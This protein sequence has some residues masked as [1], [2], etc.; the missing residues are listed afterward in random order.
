VDT[1]TISIVTPSYQQ[2][3]HLEEAMT[4]VLGQGCDRLEYV[5]CDGGS[6][7]GSRTIIERYASRLHWWRSA[8]DDGHYAAINEGFAHTTGEIMGWLNSDDRYIPGALRAVG[9]IFARF[10]TVE[11]ITSS[12]PVSLNV[13]SAAVGSWPMG[14]FSKRSFL[15]GTNLPRQGCYATGFV[16]QEST[17]WRR[18]LWERTGG[19]DTQ[20]AHA[21]DFDLWARFYEHTDLVGVDALL[22]AFRTYPEQRSS[23]AHTAYLDEAEE[24]LRRHGG[25]RYGR[26]E[27]A[28]RATLWKTLGRRSLR[29]L[30]RVAAHALV[31]IRVLEPSRTCHWIDGE[32]HLSRDY[33]M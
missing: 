33:A 26:A 4:S 11:W 12:L 3:A 8:R 19:L 9:E 29:R 17:F 22:G 10:P 15:R 13:R 30:P 7:D 31:A 16:Q 23:V 18:G 1:P 21:A 28:L 27:A 24:A 5:V 32:W 20:L 2:A 25:S 14:A 6:T